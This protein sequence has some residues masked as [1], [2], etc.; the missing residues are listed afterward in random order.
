MLTIGIHLFDYLGGI[1]KKKTKVLAF[2][3]VI[4]AIIFLITSLAVIKYEDI[5]TY[6]AAAL[7]K[8]TFTT[9]I[10]SA[11][12]LASRN[13][14]R[15]VIENEE[16]LYYSTVTSGSQKSQDDSTKG[17]DNQKIIIDEGNED[18]V[19][20]TVWYLA[21]GYTADNFETY[22]CIQN[23]NSIPINRLT[24]TYMPEKETPVIKIYS[25]DANS[26][27]TVNAKN[28]IGEK[29]FSL[30]IESD[31]DSVFY[32]ERAMYWNNRQGGTDSIALKEP[33]QVFYFAEGCTLL[34]DY[35][36]WLCV[37]NPNKEKIPVTVTYLLENEDPVVKTY[38]A[39]PES[40]LTINTGND[41]PNKSFG[42]KLEAD[43]NIIAERATYW[44]KREGGHATIGTIHPSTTWYFAEG[45]NAYGFVTW[46]TGMNPYPDPATVTITYMRERPLT[47]ISKVYTIK[48]NSRFTLD[49]ANDV[50]NEPMSIK[51]ESDLPVVFERPIYWESEDGIA[52]I[53]GHVSIPAV[54]PGDTAFFAEG[55]TADGFETWIC[56][57]NP[58]PY[59]ITIKAYTLVPK[60]EALINY[61]TI[62]ANSRFT[63]DGTKYAPGKQFA[64][65]IVSLNGPIVAERAMYWD[66]R[67]GGHLSCGIK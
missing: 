35:E 28:D 56:V 16:F 65:K 8:L 11:G 29:P 62:D 60:Q 13:S 55:Y 19:P 33:A 40:R 32:C 57:Q 49:T 53:D 48:G 4:C 36:T 54:S 25:V 14:S 45:C 34:P 6:L 39:D 38:Y 50:P 64:T 37:Q 17:E 20:A 27:L 58:N 22:I 15:F 43:K 44:S 59:P 63:L 3:I 51:V 26:R 24:F 67:R 21:E 42:V 9:D 10:I 47:P 18:T 30:K 31:D 46:L 2:F 23:P 5:K 52:S 61:Y 41:V 7:A 12:G 66:N 1:V